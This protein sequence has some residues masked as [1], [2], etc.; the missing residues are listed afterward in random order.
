ME[1]LITSSHSRKRSHDLKHPMS[2]WTHKTGGSWVSTQFGVSTLA[3]YSAECGLVKESSQAWT[4]SDAM[5]QV[6]YVLL[7]LLLMM[8]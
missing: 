8:M 2:A 5:A 4:W 7:L 3:F 6:G 1:F